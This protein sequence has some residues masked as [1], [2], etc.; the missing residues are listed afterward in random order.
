MSPL[1]WWLL[2]WYVGP[3]IACAMACSF[4]TPRS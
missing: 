3:V 2:A 4:S 1:G